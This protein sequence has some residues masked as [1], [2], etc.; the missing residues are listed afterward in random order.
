MSEENT[1]QRLAMA[2]MAGRKEVAEGSAN[3]FRFLSQFILN[4]NNAR[5]Q[6]KPF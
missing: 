5:E 6:W 2:D 4:N 1:Q 3:E